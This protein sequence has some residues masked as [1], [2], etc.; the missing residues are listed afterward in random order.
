MSQADLDAAEVFSPDAFT[1]G[2]PFEAMA[3]LRK[4]SPVHR[5]ELPD[6]PPIWLVTRHEDVAAISRNNDDFTSSNGNTF[7]AYDSPETSAMLPSLDPPR[8]TH[9]RTLINK[10]FTPRAVSRL[11][12]RVREIARTI[13]D[14]VVAA[15]EVDVVQSISAEISL[16]VIAEVMGIP[17]EDRSKI[18]HWSN[19]IGSLGVEDPDYRTS[20]EALGTAAGEMYAYCT[21]LLES[22]RSNPG[23]DIVSALLAAEVDGE[24]L[25]IPQLNEFF[26]L[27][28]VAGNETTRNTISHGLIAL[29]DNPDQQRAL[30]DHPSKIPAAT[31]E[32]VRW[33]SP[34][35]HFR[36]NAKRDLIL[37]GQQIK[38]GDWLVI[39]YLSANRD[40]EVFAN[41]DA[42]DISRSPNPHVSFGGGGSHFCLGAQ[43]ARIELRV[44]LEELFAQA[45]DFHV[46]GEPAR[47]RSAFFHGIKRLPGSVK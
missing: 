43:L 33:A 23:D 30:V 45:P 2:A 16:Q 37:R 1:S 19:A 34:V 21:A 13:V 38:S 24:H 26:M 15:G 22:K 47:L 11:E 27:L 40:S 46:T 8:H 31:E 32:M 42:F 35:I 3:R 44:M 14:D 25:T 18:F 12:S 41:A 4:D 36:R 7:V 9:F 17:M 10:G 20:L 5:V 29:T 39:H 28:A 6:L